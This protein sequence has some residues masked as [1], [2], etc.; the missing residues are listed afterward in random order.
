MAEQVV[1]VCDTCGKAPA[2]T[3]AI[4][5]NGRSY[6][7]DLCSEHLSELLANTHTARRGRPRAASAPKSG[8]GRSKAKA[9]PKGRAPAKRAT[10]SPRRRVT[11]PEILAKRRASLAKARAARAAKRAAARQVG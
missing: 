6:R 11:D 3:V 9:S 5:V 10:K 4:T 7:K 2:Q 1:V 8:R